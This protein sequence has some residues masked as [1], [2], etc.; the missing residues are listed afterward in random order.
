METYRENILAEEVE[1][2]ISGA[3]EY[4]IAAIVDWETAGWYPSYWEYGY[5]SSFPR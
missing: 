2:S 4:R 3:G 1:N 5:I